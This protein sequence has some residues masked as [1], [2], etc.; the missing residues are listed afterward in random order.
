MLLCNRL[1]NP[2]TDYIP[3]SFNFSAS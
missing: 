2:L 1:C 3:D